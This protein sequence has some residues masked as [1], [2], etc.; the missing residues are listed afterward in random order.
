VAVTD[1]DEEEMDFVEGC[2]GDLSGVEDMLLCG[3]CL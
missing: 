2:E 1:S 3:V